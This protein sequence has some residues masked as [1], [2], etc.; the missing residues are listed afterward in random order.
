MK[1]IHVCD[2]FYRVALDIVGPLPKIKDGNRYA[3]VAIDH[4][5]KWCDARFVKDHDNSTIARFLEEETICRFWC[6]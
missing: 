5:S 6:A 2:L 3:I 1:S 4:Y